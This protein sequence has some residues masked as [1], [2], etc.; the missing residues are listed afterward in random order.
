MA[1][2]ELAFV[3]DTAPVDPRFVEWTCISLAES[4]GDIYTIESSD[5]KELQ[6]VASAKEGI[7]PTSV[8]DYNEE[9]FDLALNLYGLIIPVDEKKRKIKMITMC[10][11][12]NLL[13]VCIRKMK[14]D[15][16]VDLDAM[17]ACRIFLFDVDAMDS[18]MEKWSLEHEELACHMLYI[19]INWVREVINCF[20][21][22]YSDPAVLARLIH[23]LKNL[24]TLEK[25]LDQLLPL[26]SQFVP[27]ELQAVSLLDGK[28][29]SFGTPI[30]KPTSVVSSSTV[31]DSDNESLSTN[32]TSTSKRVT[33]G[34][35]AAPS[36]HTT[37]DQLR[38]YLR[39]IKIQALSLLNATSR[40][41]E[42]KLS[43]ADVNYLLEDVVVKLESKIVVPSHPF[44][45]KKKS[46]D[47]RLDRDI[48]VSRMTTREM[49]MEVIRHMPKIL[50]A[51]EMSNELLQE[52][53]TQSGR[54]AA[55]SEDIAK[56]MFLVMTILNKLISCPE[57]AH[58]ENQDLLEAFIRTL[59][60]Q[61]AMDVTQKT[62]MDECKYAFQ[63]LAGFQEN[64]PQFKTAVSLFKT[65]ERMA[66]LS[67]SADLLHL[68]MQKVAADILGRDW[69]DWR[70]CPVRLE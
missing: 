14:N 66:Q 59:S 45:G 3:L 65:L 57:M 27:L 47:D 15:S 19:T 7:Q 22:V 2:D 32:T 70:E 12:F 69:F 8:L 53:A 29:A 60:H 26:V 37:V 39:P 43:M 10:S 62:F 36:S 55:G 5:R 6:H 56:C 41:M 44:F 4:F 46:K 31:H 17:L 40:E 23:R 13:Q 33:S 1:L 64:M 9:P 61:L 38:P 50:R 68:D 28:E 16:L 67:C 63:Y 25:R 11:H 30:I 18:V 48:S 20:C 34:K 21:P 24:T 58:P 42:P 54:I 49:L 52:D 51:M 35:A